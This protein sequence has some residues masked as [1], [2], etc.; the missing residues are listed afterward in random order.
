MPSSHPTRVFKYSMER[1]N[2]SIWRFWDVPYPAH[3][4]TAFIWRVG[5][6]ACISFKGGGKAVKR[7]D[8]DSSHPIRL[9][10]SSLYRRSG[11]LPR[12]LILSFSSCVLKIRRDLFIWQLSRGRHALRRPGGTGSF[13]GR[14]TPKLGILAKFRYVLNV[15]LFNHVKS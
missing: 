5:D 7:A 1:R 12:P 2:T 11:M 14:E 13:L 3:L 9:L 6:M 15:E 4:R 10:Y 8:P